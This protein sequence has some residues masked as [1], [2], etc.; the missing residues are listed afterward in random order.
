MTKCWRERKICAGQ[1]P[2]N[3]PL[4][5]CSLSPPQEGE[6]EVFTPPDSHITC[7][8]V[9]IILLININQLLLT[10][11]SSISNY[12][13][14]PSTAPPIVLPPKMAEYCLSS[15]RFLVARGRRH[16]LLRLYFNSSA[17]GWSVIHNKGC[18]GLGGFPPRGKSK[19]VETGNVFSFVM[20]AVSCWAGGERNN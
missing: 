5:S 16:A 19:S 2:S 14:Q 8:F 15:D 12:F 10:T 3:I 13:G 18:R 1:V 6:G 9:K 20:R 17:D 7:A 4:G 11:P